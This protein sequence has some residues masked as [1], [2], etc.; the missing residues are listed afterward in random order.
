MSHIAR[1]SELIAKV[2][3]ELDARAFLMA[4]CSADAVYP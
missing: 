3:I 1:F 4:F 2:A